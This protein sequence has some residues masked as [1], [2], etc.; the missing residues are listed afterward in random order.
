MLKFNGVNAG[1][2]HF[3]LTPG[4]GPPY[5]RCETGF[6]TSWGRYLQEEGRIKPMRGI[7]IAAES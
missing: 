2:R 4:G 5:D 7:G 6:G 1:R 3:R